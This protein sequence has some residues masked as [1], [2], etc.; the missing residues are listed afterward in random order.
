MNLND[1]V[2]RKLI[3][4]DINTGC[5]P[6]VEAI[7]DPC[8]DEHAVVAEL[9]SKLESIIREVLGGTFNWTLHPISVALH[10]KTGIIKSAEERS[11]EFERM[12][13]DLSSIFSDGDTIREDKLKNDPNNGTMGYWYVSGIRHGAIVRS[14]NALDAVEKAK[15][16]VGDWENPSA[17]WIGETLPDVYEV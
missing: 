14:D 8:V 1:Y 3:A 7:V 12:M 13:K 11:A 5:S 10:P 17:D 16:H 2:G 9:Q 4:I 6:F 15:D